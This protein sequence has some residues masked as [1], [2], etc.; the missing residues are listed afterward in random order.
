MGGGAGVMDASR[1]RLTH[2]PAGP[3]GVGAM[4]GEV[5]LDGCDHR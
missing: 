2:A 1:T 5:G 3:M 4:D